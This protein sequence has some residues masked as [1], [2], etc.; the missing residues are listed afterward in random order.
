MDVVRLSRYQG[1]R[2][3]AFDIPPQRDH[4]AGR[5]YFLTMVYLPRSIRAWICQHLA[6]RFVR[7]LAETLDGAT[8]G[9]YIEVLLAPDASEP[10]LPKTWPAHRRLAVTI[11]LDDLRRRYA[12]MIRLASAER[13]VFALDLSLQPRLRLWIGRGRHVEG[14]GGSAF[15]VVPL[16]SR[17]PPSLT[18]PHWPQALSPGVLAPPRGRL[19]PSQPTLRHL[20]R[21]C[22]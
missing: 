21:R 16:P 19:R 6:Q 4:L 15:L 18:P 1:L 13:L 11:V 8:E 20:L 9:C 3:P 22:W 17:P 10:N 7:V 5:A 2:C 14:D 12:F